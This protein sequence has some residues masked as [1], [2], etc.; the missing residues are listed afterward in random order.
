MPGKHR[1][2][3]FSWWVRQGYRRDHPVHQETQMYSRGRD[4]EEAK[5]RE[6]QAEDNYGDVRISVAPTKTSNPGRPRT[7][8]MGYDYESDRLRV[9]FREGAV[10]DY[11]DVSTAEWW[12]M[13]RSASPGRF[14]NRVL[15]THEYTR[16]S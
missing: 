7:I 8:A 10:Y 5:F 2:E 9:V 1:K 12:R 13:K 15:S 3:E 11:F 6:E 4:D 14:L 16:I